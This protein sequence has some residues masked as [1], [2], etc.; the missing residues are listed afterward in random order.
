MSVSKRE[1]AQVIE[2]Q[3]SRPLAKKKKSFDLFHDEHLSEDEDVVDDV[4][5]T[6]SLEGKQRRSTP[7]HLDSEDDEENLESV[8]AK[9]VR[10]AR[11]YIQH[12]EECCSSDEN[13]SGEDGHGGA[14]KMLSEKLVRDRLKRLG[15]FERMVAARV[16]TDLV[17]FEEKIAIKSFGSYTQYSLFATPE[18]QAKAWQLYEMSGS[19]S[20][21]PQHPIVFLKGHDL[22]VTCVALEANGNAAY[23]GSKDNSVLSWD[24]EKECRKSTIVPKWKFL[25]DK[26][27]VNTTCRRAGEV[28]ALAA[29]YDGRY[30]AVGGRDALVK[31]YDV[32]LAPTMVGSK[33]DQCGAI[34]TFQ[35]HK[36]PITSLAFRSQ[37]LQLFSGSEDGC[38]RVFSLDEMACVDTLYGHQSEVTGIDCYLRDR[39]ISIG[40]DRTAR[41]WKIAEETHL[42]YRGGSK[43]LSADCVSVVK[44]DWFFT[45]H[46]DGTISLWTTE[47]KKAVATFHSAHGH[48]KPMIV[49]C[50]ALKGSDLAATGS[51]DGYLRLWNLRMGKSMIE[52]GI[53]PV[54]A[55]PIPG[56]INGVT[57]GPKA[58]FCVAAIGQ[59]HRLGRWQRVHR[60]RNRV[61]IIQL[62]D[63]EDNMQGEGPSN[64]SDT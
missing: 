56:F 36:G 35:G 1:N 16:K 27:N 18:R 32:R 8:D 11:E 23:S 58:R 34:A 50:D 25:S 40:R 43:A 28:L 12:V 38:I 19:T 10:L 39:P 13:Q 24:M 54:S 14:N 6:S 9:R 33:K 45:G 59:E 51:C 3:G 46:E 29:S 53:E 61:A 41:A 44:D 42:I 21:N 20:Q 2:T 49:C 37:S 55:I 22:T 15:A 57:I 47:K 7:S 4:H 30:V 48:N 62:K 63:M 26:S 64:G 17:S 60:G 31:I 52:Q 5:M